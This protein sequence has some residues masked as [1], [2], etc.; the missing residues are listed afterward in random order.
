MLLEFAIIGEVIM[1]KKRKV[2]LPLRSLPVCSQTGRIKGKGIPINN[3]KKSF[4]STIN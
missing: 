1:K 3:R 4:L 2:V